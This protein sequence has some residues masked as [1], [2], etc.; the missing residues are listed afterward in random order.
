[1]VERSSARVIEITP[2]TIG[3]RR[4]GDPRSRPDPTRESSPESSLMQPSLAWE[5]AEARGRGALE[6]LLAVL[7]TT[8]AFAVLFFLLQPLGLAMSCF[9]G[10]VLAGPMTPFFHELVTEIAASPPV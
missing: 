6:R 7:L 2:T 5:K 1:M 3:P 4:S 9:G 10:L 8:I